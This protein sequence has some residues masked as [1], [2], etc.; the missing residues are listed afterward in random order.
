MMPDYPLGQTLDFKFTTR[1]FSTGAPFALVSGAVEVY[2]DNDISQIIV[3]ETLTPSFDGVVGFNNLRIVATGGNGYEVGKSYAAMLSAGTVDGV[4]VIGEVIAQFS[5]ERSPALRPTTAGRTLDV[6]ATGE[7][8]LDFGATIGTLDAAQFG[9]DF[10]TSGKIADNAFLA[11]NFAANSLDGKGN[12]NVGKT[13]YALTLADWNVGK[14]GYSL[15]QAFPTNFADLSIVITTGLVDITQAA[16]DKVWASATR[17]LTALGFTLA[18]SDLAAAI[19]TSSK[20]AANAID[21]AALATDAADEIRDSVLAGTITELGS[22]PAASPTLAQALALVYMAIRNKRDTI[23]T[24]DEI[25]NDA[26]TII[27]TASIS[28]DT[29]LFTKGKYT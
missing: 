9:A 6:A 1:Q 17:T 28:D 29:V 26:G 24:A 23:A 21:A 19:L 10:I 18:A 15:T 14:T 22:V 11:V 5:I 4:S 25:H 20:F 12:W 7:V 3:G 13:G 16:A 27:G 8:A 2:E